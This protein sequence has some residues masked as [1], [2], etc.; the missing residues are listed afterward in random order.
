MLVAPRTPRP[1]AT[2]CGPSPAPRGARPRS[3]G[4][5][6]LRRGPGDQLRFAHELPARSVLLD[7]DLL[8]GLPAARR[9]RRRPRL[10]AA[11]PAAA[12]RRQ[13]RSPPPRCPPAPVEL[14]PL[15]LSE[16]LGG[17][18]ACFGSLFDT[19]PD[20]WASAPLTET[21]YL[22][23]LLR[24]D[25][26]PAD[27][28]HLAALDLAVLRAVQRRSGTWFE[29]VALAAV[30]GAHPDDVAGALERL[31]LRPPPTGPVVGC[32]RR[33]GQAR[34]QRPCAGSG[35]AFGRIVATDVAN[36]AQVFSLGGAAVDPEAVTGDARLALVRTG[37]LAEGC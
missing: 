8:P 12:H 36:V 9:H 5:S 30:V 4:E 24:H 20:A 15:T 2:W 16:R 17:G 14:R 18:Q 1:A 23:E 7:A 22:T 10:G 29:R 26:G 11:R 25:R 32:P 19:E 6:L 35:Q 37:A 13:P 21:Q 28:D 27:P 31:E 34:G 3:L 33:A